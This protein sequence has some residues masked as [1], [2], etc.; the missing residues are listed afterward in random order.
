[1]AVLEIGQGGPIDFDGDIVALLTI[2]AT[3][4]L[5]RTFAFVEAFGRGAVGSF[6][7]ATPNI[8]CRAT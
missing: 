3:A 7:L 1:M 2:L 6:I 5:M 4:V 8:G